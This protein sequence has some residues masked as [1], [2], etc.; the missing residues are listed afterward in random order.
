MCSNSWRSLLRPFLPAL[1]LVIGCTSPTTSQT[2]TTTTKS[3]P[4]IQAGSVPRLNRV[5]DDYTYSVS[6]YYTYTGQT[7]QL[8][9]LS[10]TVEIY[11]IADPTMGANI[12][13]AVTVATFY[14]STGQTST[15]TTSEWYT[16]AGQ[17][18]WDGSNGQVRSQ[19]GTAP[20]VLAVGTSWIIDHTY[21]NGTSDSWTYRVQSSQ[22]VTC[23]YGVVA[24][25][26]E[27][28]LTTNSGG[29]SYAWLAPSIG[30]SAKIEYA[31]GASGNPYTL[32]PTLLL[33]G[34]TLGS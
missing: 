31:V 20:S 13:K 21:A 3:T 2:P 4:T 5:G 26:W 30:T 10:G 15:S 19:T 16:A 12:I 33:S 14:T 32:Y 29:V 11:F 23:P 18:Y 22:D 7:A 34:Y 28:Q 17:L 25:I 8:G 9:T 27:T 24:G 1:L 6:G